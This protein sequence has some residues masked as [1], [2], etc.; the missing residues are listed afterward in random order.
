[1]NPRNTPHPAVAVVFFALL[2]ACGGRVVDGAASTTTSCTRTSDGAE[3]A[4]TM[5]GGARYACDSIP[6][7]DAPLDVN[8]TIVST[9]AESFTVDTCP[10]NADCA[11]TIATVSVK[12]VGLDLPRALPIGTQV[13]IRFSVSRFFAC[14]RELHVTTLESWGGLKN[15]FGAGDVVLLDVIDGGAPAADAPFALDIQALG[16]VAKEVTGC[17]GRAPD[18]YT[19]WFTPKTAGAAPVSVHMGETKAL[20]LGGTPL[21][22]WA[23]RNLRSFQSEACD[24]YWNWSY[25]LAYQSPVK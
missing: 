23:V 18:D 13:R 20:P 5:P 10:P 24:D 22:T 7:T 19:F 1:M 16:C 21:G 12:A 9:A 3:L 11:G 4:V 17:G 2:A 15:P 8:A 6:E 14:Q 25:W